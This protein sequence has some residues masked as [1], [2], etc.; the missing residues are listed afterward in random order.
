MTMRRALFPSLAI[1]L[2]AC[3]PESAPSV[4][5]TVI[6]RIEKAE[7]IAD[8]HERC[9]A[10]PSPTGVRWPQELITALCA[11]RFTP[12]LSWEAFKEKVEDK[13]AKEIDTQFDAL[14]AGYY[15]GQVPEGAVL[16]AY[17][18]NFD[19]SVAVVEAM[20]DSWLD[21]SPDSA[22]AFVARG[23]HRVARAKGFRGEQFY[24]DTPTEAIE[25]MAREVELARADLERAVAQNPRIWPAYG[26]LIDVARFSGDSTLGADALDGALRVDPKNYYVRERYSAM[27]EP[28]WGGS[29]EAMDK[30]AED[31]APHLDENPRLALLRTLALAARGWPAY[32]AKDF[33]VAHELYERAVAEG[34]VWENL[35]TAGTSALRSGE[36]IRAVELYSQILRFWPWDQ[37]ARY[38]R[39]ESFAAMELDDMALADYQQV[40]ADDPGNVFAQRA[41]A[42]LLLKRE[43]YAAAERKLEALHAADPLDLWVAERLAWVYVNRRPN[44]AKAAVLVDQLL[45]AN[46]ENGAAWLMRADLIQFTKGE[47]LQ[48]A[49]ENFVRHADPSNPEHRVAVTRAKAWLQR[50]SSQ[51]SSP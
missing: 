7:Q 31:A 22:H 32:H 50:Q 2:L 42:N 36:E 41:H 28:R 33:P 5:F 43:D 47:G 14:L 49:L 19:Y 25:K 30:V 4:D 16:N 39:A 1:V 45:A 10:Y 12:R 17:Y 8:A 20:I 46:P 38:W 40:L 37:K 24:R 21:Q 13:R 3:Q 9:L 34:P 18:A 44:Y 26:A 15:D 11:D 35:L 27:L 6:A 29:F 48:E 23:I 51:S